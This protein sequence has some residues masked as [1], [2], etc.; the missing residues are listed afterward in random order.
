MD[1]L[2]LP[3]SFQ[4]K[5]KLKEASYSQIS[6]KFPLCSL[7]TYSKASKEQRETYFQ[8]KDSSI[9]KGGIQMLHSLKEIS[10]VELWR[11]REPR[12]VICFITL[13]PGRTTTKLSWT[14]FCL[15]LQVKSY[16]NPWQ[17]DLQMIKRSLWSSNWPVYFKQC[18]I[19]QNSNKKHFSGPENANSNKKRISKSYVKAKGSGRVDLHQCALSSF[20]NWK[21]RT[22]RGTR[23]QRHSE[24]IKLHYTNKV[25]TYFI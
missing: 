13:P 22:L 2:H 21:P 17:F 15:H 7:V 8:S 12:E 11:C 19:R 3:P 16:Y 5:K 9:F 23:E 4:E 25:S 24:S 6:W 14:H 20:W 18:L 1:L 10:I